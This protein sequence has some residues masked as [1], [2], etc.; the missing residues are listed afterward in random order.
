MRQ[1]LVAVV[2]AVLVGAAPLITVLAS[3]PQLFT[4]LERRRVAECNP[5]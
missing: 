5:F 1:Y 3:E 4:C 2:P